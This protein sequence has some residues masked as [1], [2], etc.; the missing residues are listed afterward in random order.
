[1]SRQNIEVWF[2]FAAEVDSECLADMAE[3]SA[4]EF[5]AVAIHLDFATPNPDLTSLHGQVT[6]RYVRWQ[7]KGEPFN[8]DPKEPF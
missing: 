1:M 2:L 4:A 6:R 3:H 8:D 5:D 7:V